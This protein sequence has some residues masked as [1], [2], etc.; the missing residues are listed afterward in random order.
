MTMNKTNYTKEQINSLLTFLEP[1]NAYDREEAAS[2]IC[3]NIDASNRISIRELLDNRY[4]LD[5]WY[6]TT[7]TSIKHT[8]ASTLLGAMKD[9][10]FS[11]EWLTQDADGTFSLPI[12]IAAGQARLIYEEV[13]RATYDHWHE[14][15]EESGLN[16]PSPADLGIPSLKHD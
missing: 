2:E 1:I 16:L 5:Q 4:F 13:Y 15:L 10:N 8:L 14:E 6:S 7:S 12:C 11:F 9:K 3:E